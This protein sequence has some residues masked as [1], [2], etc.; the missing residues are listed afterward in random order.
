VRLLASELLK[1]WTAPRTLLGLVLAELAI[2]ALATI[3]TI[4]S[5]KSEPAF[6]SPRNLERDLVGAVSPSLLFAL[7]L[8]ILVITWEYRHGTI[9]QTLLTTPVR[10]R[11]IGA[12][13]LVAAFVGGALVLPGLVL[14]LVIAEL[15]VG[16]DFHFGGEEWKQIAQLALAAAVVAVI[17]LELGACTARQIGAFVLVFAWMIFAEPALTHWSSLKD[18]LPAHAIG[19]LL[20][21]SGSEF[22]SFG[23]AALVSA[24]YL[25]G[26]GAVAL[27]LTR[28]RDIT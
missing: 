4:D 28:R 24:A 19:G 20:G 13:S 1:I 22:P 14:M 9:T 10:E 6:L 21:T 7:V 18:Y 11:V 26:L 12:K 3:S 27:A 23:K 2:V 5:W 15:W 8:G 25:L 17:G 16:E